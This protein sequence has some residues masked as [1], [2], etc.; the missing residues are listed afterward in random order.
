MA[1]KF[2]TIF[3]TMMISASA[4]AQ[5][6]PSAKAKLDA[7]DRDI[8][9]LKKGDGEKG[10]ALIRQVNAVL[11]EIQKV[12]ARDDEWYRQLCRTGYLNAKINAVALGQP[13]P[14]ENALD[15]PPS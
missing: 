9:T 14:E 1:T 11:A 2:L 7:I 8:A 5:D 3:C 12:S 15:E 13:L 10:N 4:W 6:I